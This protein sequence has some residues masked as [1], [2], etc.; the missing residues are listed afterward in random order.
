MPC[1]SARPACR[2]ASTRPTARGSSRPATISRSRRLRCAAASQ[3]ALPPWRAAK[4][5]VERPTA[6]R[7]CGTPRL[8]REVPGSRPWITSAPGTT[9]VR[10]CGKAWASRRFT[11]LS[12]R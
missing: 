12:S 1:A 3:S 9:A 6:H 7:S 2:V 11:S 8:A 5:A 10:P 4:I